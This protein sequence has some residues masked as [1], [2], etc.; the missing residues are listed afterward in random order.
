MMN[1]K[2]YK[3]IAVILLC[4]AISIGISACS[5]ITKEQNGADLK[6]SESTSA[7]EEIT[8]SRNDENVTI[9]EKTAEELAY[10]ALCETDF[11][12]FGIEATIDDFE[13]EGCVLND[14]GWRRE[15]Y[16]Y[17][18]RVWTVTYNN[19]NTLCDSIYF[20]ISEQGGAMLYCGY[21]GD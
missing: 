5:D 8:D 15:E 2:K 4:A 21:Q 19:K 7:Y 3:K 11:S 1:M 9:D 6:E 18:S 17:T 10:S 16:G 12:D 20:D 14:G 13:L